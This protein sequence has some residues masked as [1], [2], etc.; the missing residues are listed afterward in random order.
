MEQ[1]APFCSP[2]RHLDLKVPVVALRLSGDWIASEA[3]VRSAG[4]VANLVRR[5]GVRT[6]RVDAGDLGKW[7]AH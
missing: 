6:P 1:S 7:P 5:T 3:G 4:D 2:A